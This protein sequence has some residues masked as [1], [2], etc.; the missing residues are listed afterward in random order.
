MLLFIAKDN[1]FKAISMK[2]LH[3][4]RRKKKKFEIKLLSSCTFC[5]LNNLLQHCM[6]YLLTTPAFYLISDAES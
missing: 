2:N 6:I 5:T 4:F 1:M 3:N